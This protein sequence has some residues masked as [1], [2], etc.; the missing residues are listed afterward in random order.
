VAVSDTIHRVAVSLGLGDV[1]TTEA[2]WYLECS[3]NSTTSQPITDVWS[4]ACLYLAIRMHQLPIS[5]AQVAAAA[6]QDSRMILKLFQKVATACAQT[7]PPVDFTKFTLHSMAKVPGVQPATKV[8]VQYFSLHFCM[9]NSF[10][11]KVLSICC[12]LECSASA[13]LL[14]ADLTRHALRCSTC[15]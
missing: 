14:C 15:M 1:L 2:L 10:A 7:P 4:A 12:C 5:P 8:K 9:L 3:S 13:N 6:G 11:T